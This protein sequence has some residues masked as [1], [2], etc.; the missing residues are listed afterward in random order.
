MEPLGLAQFLI[1]LAELLKLGNGGLH[2]RKLIGDG[3][4]SL[5]LEEIGEKVKAR[6]MH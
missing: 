6:V 2:A 3:N 4:G 1:N 5:W